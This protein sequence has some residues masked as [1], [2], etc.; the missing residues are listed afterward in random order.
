MKRILVFAVLVAFIPVFIT[1]G[2]LLNL[3]VMVLYATLLGQA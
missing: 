3:V 2:S 1:S